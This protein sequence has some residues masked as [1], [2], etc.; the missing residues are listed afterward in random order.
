MVEVLGYMSNNN[1]HHVFVIDDNEFLCG[2]I[3]ETN[4]INLITEIATDYE[5]EKQS[6]G[7]K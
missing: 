2:V 7:G 6:E 5:E 1:L 3:S 4:I